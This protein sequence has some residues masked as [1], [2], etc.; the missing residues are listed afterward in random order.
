VS[1]P[2]VLTNGKTWQVLQGDCLEV[3]KT[4]PDASVDAVVTDPPYG[5]NTKSDGLGKLSPWADLCNSAY[6]YAA[7]IAE[8][9]RL[10]KPTGC[11]WSCLN[12]RSLVTFQ[13]AT[14][15]ARWSIE[16]VLVW[17]KDWPSTAS[18]KA[19]RPCYEMVALWAMPNFSLLD[20]SARDILQVKWS[21]HK[22]HGHPAEK[23]VELMAFC[24]K[25][26]SPAGGTV[27]DPF[28]GSGTTGVAALQTGRRFLGIEL[29]PGYFA[30]AEKRVRDA[31][32]NGPLFAAASTVSDERTLFDSGCSNGD[33]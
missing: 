28:T 26:G 17:D 11:L 8:C 18:P 14:C 5:I 30:V 19:L 4:L 12:W 13:K 25:H 24:I 20:R 9:R 23:P 1:L 3:M 21:G 27:L 22:P 33:V 16:S 15:D 31:A 32:T 29:D 7:W 10:L 6:W 2:E